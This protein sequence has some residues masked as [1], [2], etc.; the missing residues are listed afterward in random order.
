MPKKVKR[1]QVTTTIDEALLKKAKILALKN[2]KNLNDLIEEA[3]DLL[4]KT[5]KYK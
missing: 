2:D 1:K 3:L 5:K 4:L